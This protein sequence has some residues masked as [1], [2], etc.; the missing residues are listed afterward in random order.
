MKIRTVCMIAL[1]LVLAG[2]PARAHTNRS[3]ASAFVAA[4]EDAPSERVRCITL[5]LQSGD[6]DTGSYRHGQVKAFIKSF[7][8]SNPTRPCD[9]IWGRPKGWLA[10]HVVLWK[11]RGESWAMCQRYFGIWHSSKAGN[12]FDWQ[13][14][15]SRVPC[16]RGVYTASGRALVKS[17]S[18][19]WEATP[20]IDTAGHQWV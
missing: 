11:Q 13:Y 4:T 6:G 3:T 2:A 5:V 7:Q 20:W 19:G 16:G 1:S 15:F 12:T 8:A 14:T 10:S 17:R 18:H 9:D